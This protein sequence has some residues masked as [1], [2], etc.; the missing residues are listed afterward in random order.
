ME[1]KYTSPELE[2]IRFEAED[3]IGA[4]DPL[5]NEETDTKILWYQETVADP[6]VSLYYRFLTGNTWQIGHFM[7][8]YNSGKY[9]LLS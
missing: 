5:I 4:S 2:I 7:I 8:K 1:N 9:K 3:V 6:A